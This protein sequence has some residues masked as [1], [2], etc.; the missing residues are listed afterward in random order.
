M[1]RLDTV[2]S[3]LVLRR[4]K[5]DIDKALNLTKRSI[6][7]HTIT[8]QDGEKQV[9]HILFTEAR[10][11]MYRWLVEQGEAVEMNSPPGHSAA[12]KPTAVTD[13]PPTETED[14]DGAKAEE[15]TLP[16]DVQR[17]VNTIMRP[18]LTGTA[19]GRCV[20]GLLLR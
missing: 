6:E 5:E 9:Y 17:L 13:R 2:V 4:T 14:T 12:S 3:S 18:Y 8:L 16:L 1:K 19:K 11:V 7:S 20:L 15:I 10:K